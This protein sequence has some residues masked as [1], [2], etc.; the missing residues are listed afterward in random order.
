[1]RR[2]LKSYLWPLLMAVFVTTISACVLQTQSVIGLLGS[3]GAEVSLG[4]RLS[5]TIYDARHLGSIYAIFIFIAF[6]VAMTLAL[7]FTRINQKLA[8]PLY[9]GAGIVAIAI[10]LSLMKKVFFDVQI[11]AGARYSFGYLLQMLAG[12][13]GGYIFY[14]LRKNLSQQTP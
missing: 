1:M 6:L 8:A 11:I 9:I 3:A 10:M 5:M 2:F 14:R 12:G 13:L 4:N 7:L